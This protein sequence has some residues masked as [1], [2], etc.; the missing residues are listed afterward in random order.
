M[1]QTGFSTFPTQQHEGRP[2]N[3]L[4]PDAVTAPTNPWLIPRHY[5]G[6]TKLTGYIPE[7]PLSLTHWLDII[8]QDLE[9]CSVTLGEAQDRPRWSRLVNMVA[10][11]WCKRTKEERR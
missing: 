6:P 8:T 11:V 1:E 2:S 3:P 9:A 7:A 4:H 5:R 10:S